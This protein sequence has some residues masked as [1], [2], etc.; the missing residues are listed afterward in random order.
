[1]IPARPMG[2]SRSAMTSI[3]SSRR[4]ARDRSSPA[5]RRRGRDA[6]RYGRP[7]PS[8]R[9]RRA[10][11]P[12]LVHHVVGHIDHCRDGPHAGR[13]QR[14]CIQGGDAPFARRPAARREAR[15][16]GRVDDLDAD[17]IGGCQRRVFPDRCVRQAQLPPVMAATSWPG[18]TIERASPRFGFTSTSSTTSPTIG[19]SG[20]PRSSSSPAPPSSGSPQRRRPAPARSRSTACRATPHRGSST[21][22]SDGHQGTAPTIATGTRSPGEMLSAPR[23][24]AV[25]RRR[26]RPRSS[27]TACPFG[28]RSTVSSRPTTTSVQSAPVMVMPCTSMPRSSA[29]SARASGGGRRRHARAARRAEPALA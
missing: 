10:W 26:R 9:R 4:A 21:A 25:G 1:M 8:P 20:A 24:S 3:R 22:R 16:G 12:Q 29:C 13:Q 28:W 19:P 11:L 27:A 2:C 18:H 23:R 5:S 6:P 14:C 17:M 7:G 15:T